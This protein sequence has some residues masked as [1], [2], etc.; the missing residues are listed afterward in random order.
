MAA[1]VDAGGVS[2][3]VGQLRSAS[4]TGERNL[5]TVDELRSALEEIKEQLESGHE[6][7]RSIVNELSEG[8]RQDGDEVTSA[9][10]AL[11]ATAQ[12]GA[13][14]RLPGASGE[15]AQAMSSA[16]SSHESES[17]RLEE[18][19]ETLSEQGFGEAS[20]TLAEVSNN[21]GAAASALT[22][23][24][25]ELESERIT[26][27][28]E[29]L[30]IESA[31]VEQ[32]EAAAASTEGDTAQQLQAGAESA[33]GE[34]E[35]LADNGEQ[36]ASAM[37]TQLQQAYSQWSG[38]QELEQERLSSSMSQMVEATVGALFAAAMEQ[39]DTP[40]SGVV[41]NHAPT[42][43]GEMQGVAGAAG[44]WIQSCTDLASAAGE[45]DRGH[46]AKRRLDI[47]FEGGGG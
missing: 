3:L 10:E 27:Q 32:V 31:A 16:E 7:L 1:Q 12:G 38:E 47:L 36:D 8:S 43:T 18:L 2:K 33:A 26:A 9:I 39:L 20:T 11:T 17:E 44:N 13:E 42:A 5:A 22:G 14:N 45:L 24:L 28:E 23:A 46:D 41:Q 37:G 6:G 40:C 30:S 35:N 29:L 15:L 4:S 21:H 25:A 19:T 34:L